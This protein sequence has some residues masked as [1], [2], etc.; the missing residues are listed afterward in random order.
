MIFSDANVL[1]LSIYGGPALPPPPR[2]RRQRNESTQREGHDNIY[3]NYGNHA[4]LSRMGSTTSQSSSEAGSEIK[5]IVQYQDIDY[6]HTTI[7]FDYEVGGCGAMCASVMGNVCMCVV[8][9]VI[10]M[11][12]VT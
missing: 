10:I 1:N 7:Q 5:G 4:E 6:P 3:G 2:R 8:Y 12:V 9:V 11:C